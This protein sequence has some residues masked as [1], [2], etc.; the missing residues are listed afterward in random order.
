M[1][2][3]LPIAIC[4]SVQ[5]P[6]SSRGGNFCANVSFCQ[7][8]GKTPC[9]CRVWGLDWVVT[10]LVAFLDG[11]SMS[12]LYC[13]GYSHAKW[14]RPRSNL[15]PSDEA[16]AAFRVKPQFEDWDTLRT[17]CLA[18]PYM[19]L[20]TYSCDM[21]N[22][23]AEVIRCMQCILLWDALSG[24]RLGGLAKSWAGDG[25]ATKPQSTWFK[26][27]VSRGSAIRSEGNTIVYE[28]PLRSGWP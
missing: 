23:T 12:Q 9:T 20:R 5:V 26:R 16:F 3:C 21:P 19:P 8:P 25:V 4:S 11:L 7:L 27:K 15:K 6:V 10:F 17:Q 22:D 1:F 24:F 13:L 28:F 2:I 18:C 14:V